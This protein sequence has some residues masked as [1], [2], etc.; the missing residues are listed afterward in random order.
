MAKVPKKAS[1]AR[2]R[3][4]GKRA[5]G[6]TDASPPRGP[7]SEPELGRDREPELDQHR[8]TMPDRASGPYR[9]EMPAQ[10]ESQDGHN[11]P[12]RQEMLDR[13]PTDDEV[14]QRAYEIYVSRGQEP[15]RHVEDWLQARRELEALRGRDPA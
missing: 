11:V 10:S 1:A 3:A 2:P 14:A 6:V 5:G 12:D 13:E 9:Q 15:G 7:G 8:E 4:A